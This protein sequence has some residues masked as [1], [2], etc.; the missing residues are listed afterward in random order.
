MQ[1]MNVYDIEL[2]EAIFVKLNTTSGVINKT[3]TS[4]RVFSCIHAKSLI[5]GSLK[6][7]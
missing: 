5:V 7:T 6:K 3:I 2:P 1:Q 4:D